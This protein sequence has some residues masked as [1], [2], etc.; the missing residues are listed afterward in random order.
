M[1]APLVTVIIATYNWSSV[2]RYSIASVL[3][4]TFRD[5]ELLVVGDGCTDDSE[6]VVTAIDDPRVRWINL[7]EN[8]G[9][10]SGPNNRGLREARG[11][12]IAY[13]GHDD[14][15][16][17]HHLECMTAALD[18][19]G[20]ALAYSLL[21]RVFPGQDVGTPLLPLPRH[22]FWGS[23][24][25]TVH[26]RCV[27][28]SIGGW[29][30]HRNLN[31]APDAELWSRMH[32]A[33]YHLAFVPRLTAIKFPAMF[34][35]NVY[36]DKPSH[37]QAAWLQRIQSDPHF[38]AEHLVSMILA[39]EA[40]RAMPAHALVPLVL[41]E[42][43]KRLVWRLSPRSG[44]NALF[45]RAKGGAIDVTRKYKGLQRSQH[46]LKEPKC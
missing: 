31:R 1:N 35:R 2:L 37:E 22:R 43:G 7:P 15:W 5:F 8:T 34:R 25:C 28:D 4:Q 19:D 3:A 17:P 18:K 10:Q 27:T 33:G 16:L 13:L 21:A 12:F 45:W 6:Q 30:E 46:E 14:L 42:L 39:G 44:L 11:E 23:P 32:S 41:R 36:R 40:A 20:A 26:R 9:H 38:E 29:A 24:S